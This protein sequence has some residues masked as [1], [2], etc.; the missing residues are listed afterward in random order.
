MK[1]VRELTNISG[2]VV[3]VR[4]DFNIENI[5]DALRLDRSVPTISYL[6]G[7]GAVVLLISH[8]GRP[9][10]Q[11]VPAL[12]MRFA[13]PFLKEKISKAVTFVEQLDF[14]RLKKDLTAAA[15]GS[16]WLLE[17]IRFLPQEEACDPEFAKKLAALGDYY[18]DDAFAVAHHPATSM[19]LLPQLLPSYGGLLVEQEV[20]HLSKA[21]QATAHPFVVV[22]GG[23]KA[24]DK[25]AMLE[26]LYDKVD[27][28]LVGGILANTFFKARGD[29]MHASSI[30]DSILLRVK[31]YLNDPKIILPTDWV[32]GDD[33]K[34]LDLGAQSAIAF[35]KVI[36]GAKLVVWSGPLGYFE[37]QRYRAG[38]LAIAEAIVASNAFSIVGG[39]ETTQFILESKME[40]QFG[41]LSTGGGAML[42]FL[43]GKK[44][45]GLEA[46]EK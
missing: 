41:F 14:D 5:H 33:G 27:Q 22:I 38:S 24:E 2:K 18:V 39:G 17:N 3:L 31:K 21:L 6:L 20:E 44:L 37:D 7:Q 45:P 46:L 23:G 42:D 34:I 9:K 13:L 4:V 32:T 8:R 30:D 15:P 29:E 28:F 40:N 36:A 10:G 26:Y 12:S 1:S 43:S 16:L 25:F 19:T 35:A 11:V